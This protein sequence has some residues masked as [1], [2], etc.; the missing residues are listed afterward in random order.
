M[1]INDEYKIINFDERQVWLNANT[2]ANE[3]MHFEQF[4]T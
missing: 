2:G 1:P 3:I 4:M